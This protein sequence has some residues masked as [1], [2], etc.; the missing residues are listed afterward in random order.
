MSSKGEGD[1]D[2]DGG[3]EN[4][5]RG[6]ERME[7]IQTLVEIQLR[8]RRYHVLKSN[9]HHEVGSYGSVCIRAD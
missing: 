5:W 9:I 6:E 2:T 4:K 8:L 7:I 1:E 3:L